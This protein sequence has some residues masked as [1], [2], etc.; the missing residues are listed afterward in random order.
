MHAH[1]HYSRFRR[2]Q[3][4]QLAPF[5]LHG[6]PTRQYAHKRCIAP[7][8]AVSETLKPIIDRSIADFD[9]KDLS[10]PISGIRALQDR[11]ASAGDEGD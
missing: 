6:L 5:C 9:S 2:D 1:I 3:N 10:N 11:G 4:H 8:S 7:S